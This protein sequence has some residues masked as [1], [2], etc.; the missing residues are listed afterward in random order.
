MVFPVYS[1]RPQGSIALIPSRLELSQTLRNPAGK[2]QL[3]KQAVEQLEKT[4]DLVVIDCAPTESILTT[5]AY[6]MADF[7][8]IPVRPEFLSTIGLPLLEQSL[9]EFAS[10]YPNELPDILGIVFNAICGYSPEDLTSRNQVQQVAR[11]GGWP[12]FDEEMT[13][14]KSFPKSAREG[15]PIFWTSY[16]RLATRNNF[17][18]FA[19]EFAMGAS[20]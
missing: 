2:E 10:R 4:Y 1:R 14:S 5:S 9:S 12:V 16:A 15:R 19:T 20:I 3:L 17:H 18:K 6:L 7:L 8:L 11:T 13:H